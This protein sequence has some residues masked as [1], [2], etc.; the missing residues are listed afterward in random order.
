MRSISILLS[1]ILLSDLVRAETPGPRSATNQS[2]PEFWDISL[3]DAVFTALENTEVARSLSARVLRSPNLVASSFDPAIQMSDP[4]FGVEA[5]L[6]DFDA[7]LAHTVRVFENDRVFNNSA[8]GGGGIEVTQDQFQSVLA[9]SKTGRLG[10]RFDFRRTTDHDHNNQPLNLFSHAWQT[11]W[12]ASIS[13]PLWQGAGRTFNEISGP[14]AAPGQFRGIRIARMNNRISSYQFQLGLTDFVSELSQA[15]WT[16]ELSY[17]IFQLNND[18][19]ESAHE[20]WS[21]VRSKYD[22]GLKGGEADREAQA[23]EQLLLFER[24]VLDSLNGIYEA[25]RRL[26]RLMGLA[27]NDGLLIRPNEHPRECRIVMDWTSTLEIAMKYRP[28]PNQQRWRVR[29]K[30]LE[31]LAARN[32]G[33][34]RLDVLAR[35]RVRGFGDDLFG[36]G[37][38][39][40]SAYQDFLSGDH[41]EWEFGG[42]FSMPI[43]RRLGRTAIRNAELQLAREKEVLRE[44]SHVVAHELADAIAEYDR[45]YAAINLS[46]ERLEAAVDVVSAR[47]AGLLAGR[48][49]LEF[50]LNSQQRLSTAEEAYWRAMRDHE[51]ANLRVQVAKGTLVDQ[52]A[53]G[54]TTSDQCSERTPEEPVYPRVRVPDSLTTE[55]RFSRI[56]PPHNQPKAT[57]GGGFSIRLANIPPEPI[58]T[59]R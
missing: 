6:A 58:S 17:R 29:Q 16:L 11:N 36:E 20:T 18:A 25:E 34:P 51:V 22:K 52:L 21:T 31:L 56:E 54:T 49:P 47:N 40:A 38:R 7:R 48:V 43:G 42:Q 30:E 37:A 55:V 23:R 27:V 14:G 32:Q 39:F 46:R 53:V 5:A 50:L 45:S 9:L 12:Q 2:S 15:Y 4:R 13:Q 10:T 8:F 33:M 28:E 19:R 44:Q 57:S 3:S 35:Y 59:Q 24:R 26:R 1:L 41:Q